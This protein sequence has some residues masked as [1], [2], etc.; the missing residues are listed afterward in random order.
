[1]DYPP[2]L[3]RPP[4]VRARPLGWRPAGYSADPSVSVRARDLCSQ[5]CYLLVALAVAPPLEF[6]R[7]WRR[8]TPQQCRPRAHFP[9]I[10]AVVKA[11]TWARQRRGCCGSSS[12]S[13]TVCCWRSGGGWAARRL[14]AGHR[15]RSA[16]TPSN[17]IPQVAGRGTVAAGGGPIRS[18]HGRRAIELSPSGPTRLG[19][20][21]C[22]GR[23]LL[24]GLPAGPYGAGVA[25]R[26]QPVLVRS[27]P[28]LPRFG[29]SRPAASAWQF[30]SATYLGGWALGVTWLGLTTVAF[31]NSGP[32]GGPRGAR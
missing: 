15:G 5:C 13:C 12:G 2:A 6:G 3:S 11:I 10:V 29:I 31:S 8:R 28:H 20:I 1:M 22:Y 23:P 14:P 21:V 16:F 30:T 7:P 17:P 32:P 4:H 18:P 19:S 26:G 24:L 27:A 25:Y 9:A